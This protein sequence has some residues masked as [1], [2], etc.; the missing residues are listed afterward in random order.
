MFQSFYQ[1][2]PKLKPP[3]VEEVREEETLEP[4]IGKPT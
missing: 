2:M 4:V 1:Y 3:K